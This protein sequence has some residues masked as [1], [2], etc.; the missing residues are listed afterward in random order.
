MKTRP[1]SQ[2][3]AYRK[4]TIGVDRQKTKERGVQKISPTL[5]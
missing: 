5:I 1:K 4:Y 3:K 2:P